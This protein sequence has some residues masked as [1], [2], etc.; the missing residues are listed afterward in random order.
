MRTREDIAEKVGAA[1]SHAKG[2]GSGS[3]LLAIG[4]GGSS[5]SMADAV[6]QV[7]RLLVL[8]P[9]YSA[10]TNS[11]P[12]ADAT[13]AGNILARLLAKLRRPAARDLVRFYRD[14]YAN[15]RSPTYML[16]SV[17][18]FRERRASTQDTGARPEPR[19]GSRRDRM[20]ERNSQ[21]ANINWR[22]RQQ[23]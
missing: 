17:P 14:F 5:R 10:P 4:N 13:I 16:H 9:G 20:G 18:P 8:L 15:P 6:L 2:R 12:F 22:R 23:I 21:A 11:E 1:A 7:K 19:T 3:A